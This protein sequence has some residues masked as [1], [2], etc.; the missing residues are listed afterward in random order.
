MT[1]NGIGCSIKTTASILSTL[2]NSE[3]L[4]DER[5]DTDMMYFVEEF[6][7]FDE[8]F[9]MNFLTY[10]GHGAY[11]QTDFNIHFDGGGQKVNTPQRI[12]KSTPKI[13]SIMA[14]AVPVNRLTRVLAR[15]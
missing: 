6:V 8:P 15:M 13:S 3:N 4:G 10:S 12:A 9:Y 11:N 14:T 2:S 5:Y 7:S 1:T